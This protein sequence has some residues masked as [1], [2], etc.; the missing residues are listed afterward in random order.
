MSEIETLVDLF[1]TSCRTRG[2]APLFGT[3]I[4][5]EFNWISYESVHRRVAEIRL[6]LRELR[7]ARGDRVALI[8]DNSVDWA[9]LC[10]A[11]AGCGGVTV[12]MYTAQTP[13][14]WQYILND[15]AA[16]VAFFDFAKVAAPFAKIR[17]NL[18]NLLHAITIDGSPQ[19]K[20]SLPGLLSALGG[21]IA[22]CERPAAR[23]RT[24]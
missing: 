16:K 17:P 19:D 9:A 2:Q 18:P 14:D 12:P 8:A 13:A 20:T 3:K 5:D 24:S 22:E 1:E 11:T 6:V 15:C 23:P 10:Y 7:I 21:R 4:N